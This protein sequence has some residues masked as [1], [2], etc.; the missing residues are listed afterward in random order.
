MLLSSQNNHD[1]RP[2]TGTDDAPLH[3]WEGVARAA[4][5]TRVQVMMSTALF[6]EHQAA[7]GKLRAERAALVWAAAEAGGTND[8]ARGPSDDALAAAS[9]GGAAAAWASCVPGDLAG[10][11]AQAEAVAALGDSLAAERDAQSLAT[12]RQL[13][14]VSPAQ[15]AVLYAR[16]WPFPLHIA[17]I[18]GILSGDLRLRS[19]EA[20]RPAPLTTLAPGTRGAE[21]ALR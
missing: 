6:D 7:L 15:H 11:I 19:A 5:L 17:N 8:A 18:L 9:E 12:C 2:V 1:M 20:F 3:F 21:A 4:C 14:L 10:S 16:C 13:A